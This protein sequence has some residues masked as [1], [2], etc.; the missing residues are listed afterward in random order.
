MFGEVEVRG[1]RGG[2]YL[3]IGVYMELWRGVSEQNV[4]GTPLME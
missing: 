3:F 2:V 4:Q 1:R